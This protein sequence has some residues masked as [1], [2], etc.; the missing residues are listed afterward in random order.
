MTQRTLAQGK[1]IRLVSVDGWEYAERVT[2]AGVVIILAVTDENKVLLTEQFRKPLRSRVIEFPAGLVGDVAGAESEDFA[3][4]VRRELLE[5]TG[6]ETQDVRYVTRGPSSAGLTNEVV[7]FYRATGLT[8]V[9]PGGGDGSE[10][11]DV[12]EV[13]LATVED[14]LA[15]KLQ[16]GVMVDPKVYAGLYF[17]EREQR[18][19]P[20]P[21]LKG[22]GV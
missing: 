22:R 9:G 5:E 15:A 16:A 4:A 21:S 2:A 1:Y 7:T 8:K 12:H 10:D 19:S 14:W 18:P 20:N 3:E 11:I 13:P 17:I 6:Y